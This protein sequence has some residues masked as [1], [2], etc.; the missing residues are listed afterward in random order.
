MSGL[1]IKNKISEFLI[2]D[3]ANSVPS[4]SEDDLFSVNLA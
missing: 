2:E 3:I 4:I 1:L